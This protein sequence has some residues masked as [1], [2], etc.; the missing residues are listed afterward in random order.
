MSCT[1]VVIV[2]FFH[3]RTQTPAPQQIC[4]PKPY[5]NLLGVQDFKDEGWLG[6]V[7]GSRCRSVGSTVPVRVQEF[8]D[9][10]VMGVGLRGFNGL[11]TGFRV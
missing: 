9:G 5:I 2:S 6:G 7:E 11:G 10:V 1:V 4:S 3:R 8:F